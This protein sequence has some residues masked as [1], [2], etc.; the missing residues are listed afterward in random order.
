MLEFFNQH[1]LSFAIWVPVLA[2]IIVLATANEKSPNTTRWLA[3]LG[4]IIS[5]LVTIP[6]YTH[7]NF[8]DGGFQFQEGFSWIPAFNVFYHLG[9]DGLAVP[10]ILLTSFTTVIVIISAWDVIE[11]RVSQYMAS[12]LIMSGLMIGVFSALDAILYYVFWEAMLIPMFLV[13]GIWGGP[14]RVYATIK[15]FLYTLL[16]SLLML[17]A[18]IFLFYQTGSFA[19]TDYYALEMPMQAQVL[20]F[21][22]FFAA[23]AVKIPMWPVHTWLPDAHV[24]APTGGSVVLA[25]IMLKLGGYSFLRFAMPIAPDAAHYLTKFMVVLS[26]IAIVYIMFVALVQKDMKKL[27][28]YSSISHMGFVTLGFFMF[29]SLALEGAIV[30]MISH[31]F[32]S[33]AM[34]LCVGV[35]YDRVHSRQIES[36]GGVANTMPM[37]AAFF[38][39]FAM[40][41]SGLPGTSGFVGEFMVILGTI[42]DNFWYAFLASLTLIFGAAYSLWMIKRVLYG[43]VANA[44]VAALKDL[45]KREFLILAILA[46]LVL[47]LGLYPL[48]LTEMT[49]ATVTQLLTHFAHSKIPAALP[50]GL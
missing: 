27:I 15:F 20:I 40:A 23:F 21:L 4:G 50:T 8:A 46:L 19:I 45:N 31:G 33:A 36:Y 38:V 17:V 6:L 1:L 49:N 34:F 5:F 25:A 44:Q 35:L 37:F 48:P 22:A 43:E 16:G 39:L 24:E 18:F 26:L 47:A 13:I 28:A 14:N 12:F 29:N 3:L 32:I 41:N 42:Q 9:A 7:F 11:K 10:L 30:Q 2:G